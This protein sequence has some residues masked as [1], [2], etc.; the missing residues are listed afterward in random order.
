MRD[1]KYVV[2]TSILLR[3]AFGEA[4]CTTQADTQTD[5]TPDLGYDELWRLQNDFYERWISP[6]NVKE[7][8]SIN[9]TIFAE[10]ARPPL[11]LLRLAVLTVTRSKAAC[12]IP[13]PLLA[14]S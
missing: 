14:V 13:V 10:N 12:P 9:S 8:E 4:V 5:P 6:N 2:A 3:L 7:A 11:L 1:P